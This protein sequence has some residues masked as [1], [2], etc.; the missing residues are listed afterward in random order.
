MQ[1]FVD[2]WVGNR[3]FIQHTDKFVI[4]D[5]M[6]SDTVT[7]SNF[8]QRSRSFLHRMNDRLRKILNHSSENAM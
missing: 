1:P 5:D 6:D 7:E 4:F 2:L 3:S 8:S